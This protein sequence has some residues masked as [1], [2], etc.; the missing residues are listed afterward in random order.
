MGQIVESKNCADEASTYT[1]TWRTTAGWSS[2]K[3]EIYAKGIGCRTCDLSNSYLVPSVEY[4]ATSGIH[5]V[6]CD[7]IDLETEY[8]ENTENVRCPTMGQITQLEGYIIGEQEIVC[9][10]CSN[11]VPNCNF[12]YNSTSCTMCKTTYYET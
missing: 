12:C 7:T 1:E 5:I 8:F 4:D 10:D 3:N 6:G 9:T 11:V 2:S